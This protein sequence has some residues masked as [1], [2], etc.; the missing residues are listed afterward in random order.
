MV[1]DAPVEF[2]L[3]QVSGT[4]CVQK[5][6]RVPVSVTHSVLATVLA[7][8]LSLDR[9]RRTCA[10]KKK[11]RQNAPSSARQTLVREVHTP[12][13]YCLRAG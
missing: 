5:W 2:V 4:D 3:M 11:K 13:H 12:T 9:N 1:R 7:T 6:L 8:G 10:M